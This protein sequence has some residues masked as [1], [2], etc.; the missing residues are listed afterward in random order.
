MLTRKLR[1]PVRTRA[2]FCYIMKYVIYSNIL[3]PRLC[4]FGVGVCNLHCVFCV[5]E[6]KMCTIRNLPGRRS[7]SDDFQHFADGKFI[8]GF[9]QSCIL[10][11][12]TELC[13]PCKRRILYAFLLMCYRLKSTSCIHGFCVANTC[14][15]P[16]HDILSI[17]SSLEHIGQHMI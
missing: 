5:V 2:L 1:S 9:S 12:H 10:N 15:T 3:K 14:N 16:H 7:A 4:L 13:I 11:A 6:Y 8:G 17:Q